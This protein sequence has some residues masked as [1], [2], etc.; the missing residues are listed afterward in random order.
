MASLKLVCVLLV[1]MVVAA[2]MAAQAAFSCGQVTGGLGPC[3][4]YLRNGGPVPA[5]CCNGV[6]GLVNA[7]KTT[8]DRQAAC[9]CLKDASRSIPG[10]KPGNAAALPKACNVNIGYPISNNVNCN[11]VK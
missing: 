4:G 9:R 11:T 10:I 2:P 7:A 8:A 3:L 1:C 6:R 5:S